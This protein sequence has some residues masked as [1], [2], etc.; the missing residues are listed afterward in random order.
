MKS[1]ALRPLAPKQRCNSNTLSTALPSMSSI[2][3]IRVNTSTDNVKSIDLIDRH[4]VDKIKAYINTR[5]SLPLFSHSCISN[6]SAFLRNCDNHSQLQ[7][8]ISAL[9]EDG[10]SSLKFQC[11]VSKFGPTETLTGLFSATEEEIQP[12]SEL[13]GYDQQNPTM[14]KLLCPNKPTSPQVLKTCHSRKNDN[15]ISP[16]PLL[17]STS[18]LHPADSAE[19]PNIPPP[20]SCC[21]PP[22]KNQQGEVIRVVTCR[23]GDSC[24]CVGCDAHPSRAMKESTKDVYI[25]FS[26]YC[27]TNQSKNLSIPEICSEAQP[28]STTD[29]PSSILSDDGVLLCGCGC[30]KALEDCT[31]CFNDM[32]TPCSS[33]I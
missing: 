1:E 14:E 21:G 7:Q 29:H 28:S 15:S 23:C 2:S 24:A 3:A 17:S 8:H 22:S 9:A 13:R 27:G 31:C 11:C 6:S 18:I 16:L 19:L 25:G 4:S 32:Y 5:P 30:L 20:S 33:D 10:P 12:H 26:D